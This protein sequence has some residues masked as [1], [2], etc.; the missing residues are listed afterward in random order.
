[1]ASRTNCE[2]EHA[3]SVTRLTQ[4]ALQW[5]KMARVALPS[6]ER[7]CRYMHQTYSWPRQRSDHEVFQQAAEGGTIHQAEFVAAILPLCLLLHKTQG[8][9]QL[10]TGHL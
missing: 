8:M 1:M 5:T 10:E 9:L 7:V 2:A 6:L 4:C 3:A